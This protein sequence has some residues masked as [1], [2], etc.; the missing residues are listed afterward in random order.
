MLNRRTLLG[1]LGLSPLASLVK[2]EE[3]VIKISD[4]QARYFFL[5]GMAESFAFSI[6]KIFNDFPIL[7]PQKY[8]SY[9]VENGYIFLQFQ[10]QKIYDNTFSMAWNDKWGTPEEF[11]QIL[12]PMIKGIS[13]VKQT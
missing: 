13:N 12:E 7:T 3:I 5:L 4:T 8:S 2:T 9:F 10:K 1:M 11:M 6:Q